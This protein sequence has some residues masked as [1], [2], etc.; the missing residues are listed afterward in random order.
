MMTEKKNKK[1]VNS[2]RAGCVTTFIA[3]GYAFFN[4]TF[5]NDRMLF[6]AEPLF[7]T[8]TAGKWF[9]QFY[10][11]VHGNSYLPWISGILMMLYLS[12]SVFVTVEVLNLENVV[13]IWIIAALYST[14]ISIITGNF[15][16]G[17]DF[18]F[19][20]MMAMLSVLI[21]WQGET[22]NSRRKI[23]DNN[24][25]N[26]NDK[27][28]FNFGT[29]GD[30]DD[31][32]VIRVVSKTLNKNNMLRIFM[33]AVPIS[34]CLGEYGSFATAAPTLVI[35]A[36]IVMLFTEKDIGYI[37]RRGIEYIVIFFIGMGIYYAVLRLFLSVQNLQMQSYMG[38]DRLIHGISGKEL[39]ECFVLAYKNPIKYWLGRWDGYSLISYR[40]SIALILLTL[41]LFISLIIIYR[42]TIFAGR[43]W[44]LLTFLISVF[45]LS[46]GAIYIIA[47]GNVHY[48]MIF[49]F[50]LFYVGM[51]KLADMVIRT[52]DNCICNVTTKSIHRLTS[53]VAVIL[54]GLFLVISYI[55]VI[56]AN[57]AYNALQKSNLASMSIAN[58]LMDRIESCDGANGDEM[59][60]FIGDLCDNDY[61]RLPSG[62]GEYWKNQIRGLGSATYST[63][64]AYYGNTRSYLYNVMGFYRDMEYYK[65]GTMS[66]SYTIEDEEVIRQMPVFPADGSVKIIEG[67]ITV[68]LSED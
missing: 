25:R 61:Y 40:L 2:F 12:I 63:A 10:S 14:N 45:P 7:V 43:K 65:L 19:A 18:T 39:G 64:F 1:L 35:M 11:Y 15:F 66:G 8:S 28:H 46:T 34:V 22:D 56:H 38:E 4:S 23:V 67:I 51:I 16:N 54:I 29:E 26:I 52:K 60:V 49:T 36:C 50:V 62:E 21:W 27:E 68:K 20:L 44:I 57:M 47:F 31:L 30:R 41:L 32:W 5:T 42:T 9:A 33:A 24:S 59:I 13:C 3:H 6:F 55:G 37:L 58:R 53:V 17:D 48:L